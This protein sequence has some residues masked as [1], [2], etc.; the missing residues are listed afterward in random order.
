MKTCFV[1]VAN[2]AY[3]KHIP[4][5][6]Y[7]ANR[8]YPGSDVLVFSL[9]PVS[10][11]VKEATGDSA[12]IKE[13]WENW[14]PSR[15]TR[16]DFALQ[17]FLLGAEHLHGYDAAYFGDIDIMLAKEK[18]NLWDSHEAHADEQN[19]PY[20][21]AV[22][23]GKKLLT[24]LH[25]VRVGAYFEGM[26]K[27]IQKYRNKSKSGEFSRK[28]G[29]YAHDY[30]EHIL[31]RMIRESELDFPCG[32]YRPHHGLHVGIWRYPK[33]GEKVTKSLTTGHAYFE[34]FKDYLEASSSDQFR[35]LAD[36]YPLPAEYL[37]MEKHLRGRFPQL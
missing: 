1:V 5:F 11:E 3:H 17:R 25:Y 26:Q 30:D 16:N 14:L 34:Y 31:F 6:S 24:G 28:R 21:N 10:R 19:L 4:F 23:A 20:S 35:S 12:T 36:D 7:F 37:L 22:R 9:G 18:D 33:Y 2:S 8:A 29:Q 27:V 32:F 13:K 15:P